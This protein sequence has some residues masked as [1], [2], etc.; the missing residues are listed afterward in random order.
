MPTIRFSIKVD[1]ALSDATSCVLADPAAAYGVRRAD[2]QAVVVAADTAMT[3]AA[4]GVY[5]H[6]FEDPAP[7]LSYEYY[8][9][10]VLLG[11]TYY[12]E[13]EIAGAPVAGVRTLAEMT[14]AVRAVLED[15]DEAVFS[16]EAIEQAL[17]QAALTASRYVPHESRE[18]LSMSAG[19]ADLS[20][21]GISGLRRVVRAEY[22]VG[23]N[24]RQFRNVER[25]GDTVTVKT[26]ALPAA[27]EAV[28]LYCEKNHTLTD[29]ASTLTPE[30]EPV[31]ADLAAGH[32]ALNWV[33]EGRVQIASA[34][35]RFES[36]ADIYNLI[37]DGASD[38]LLK[39]AIDDIQ[40]VRTKMG[41]G[42]TAG[43][44]KDIGDKVSEASTR[45]G[46]ALG[47]LTE[48]EDPS[49]LS[50]TNSMV[51][52][53]LS[54]LNEN[55]DIKSVA[56]L[57]KEAVVDISAASADLKSDIDT[58]KEDDPPGILDDIETA[59]DAATDHL[60]TGENGGL[61]LIN[62]ITMG[63]AP[64]SDYASY[65]GG[66]LGIARARIAQAGNILNVDLSNMAAAGRELEAARARLQLAATYQIK[67]QAASQYLGIVSRELQAAQGSLNVAR[68]YY[69]K[70]RATAT[71]FEAAL[72]EL[73]VAGAVMS[74]LGVYAREI[75][76]RLSVASVITS[77]QRWALNKIQAATDQLRALQKPRAFTTYAES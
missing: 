54:S 15:E 25:F 35:T 21:A 52:D 70:L 62:T 20:V 58:I 11:A 43:I 23:Q 56:T 17:S 2:T 77:Y 30:L 1:G 26:A 45:L 60:S 13:G 18:S 49:A 72:R 48:A 29:E 3:H 53:V 32:A 47:R 71:Y 57:L 7:G 66:E 16:D 55:G 74:Q 46:D 39:R 27:G 51:E 28:Y 65:A 44:I 68:G 4:T 19:S 50:Y 31:V 5:E 38:G 75:A 37:G 14:A 9:R 36:Y 33:G 41:D 22:R 8:V 6:A 63:A 40:L 61:D 12:S 34:V 67:G 42:T 59:I 69:E 73:S 24:P 64:V 10:Y 76:S